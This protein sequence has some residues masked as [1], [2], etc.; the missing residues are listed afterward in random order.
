[1]AFRMDQ[2]HGTFPFVYHLTSQ[3]NL[4]RIMRTGHLESAAALMRRAAR[5]DLLR[6]RRRGS[7]PI[8][9]D[10]ETILLRDQDPLHQ[11]NILFEGGWGLP[12]LIEHLNARVFFWPGG[13]DGPIGHGQRHYERY[14]DEVPA[15]MRVCLRSLL[16]ANPGREPRFCRRN[17]GSPRTVA[18][19]KS[20]RGPQ[21]FVACD[22]FPGGPKSVVEVTFEEQVV[23]P[24]E[25][26]TRLSTETAWAPLTLACPA[27]SRA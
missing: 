13:K 16:N 26:E 12:E 10:G 8:K 22:Q 9:I 20:P 4:R 1:M 18:G 15:I 25:A 7:L 21:T 19:K 17:S 23:L 24:P 2:L 27:T 11:G 6:V 3:E 5:L 14:R